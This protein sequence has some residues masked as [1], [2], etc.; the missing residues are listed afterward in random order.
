[1]KKFIIFYLSIFSSLPVQAS[2]TANEFQPCKK[3]AVAVLEYCLVQDEKQCWQ[4]SK[5]GF[6]ACRKQVI[7]SHNQDLDRKKAEITMAKNAQSL[8]GD[9]DK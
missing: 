9:K 8:E 5:L 6:E 3:K 2:A 1:M 7:E 4:K